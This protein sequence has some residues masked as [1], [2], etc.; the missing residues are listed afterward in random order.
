M[1]LCFCYLILTARSAGRLEAVAE[2]CLVKGARDVL[3]L[4]YD[5]SDPDGLMDLSGQAWEAFG[6]IDILFL[7]A[8]ISQRASVE[9]TSMEMV[10]RIMEVGRSVLYDDYDLIYEPVHI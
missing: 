2:K 8:G 7:N 10:R 5:F 9:D 1:W 6:G 4:P 3:V